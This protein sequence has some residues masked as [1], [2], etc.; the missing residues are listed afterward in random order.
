MKK[1]ENILFCTD[2]DGTLLNDD[3]QIS[4]ENLD[5]IEYFKNE[6][7]SFSFIT[8]RPYLISKDICEKIKPNVPL[9]CFNGGGLYDVSKDEFIW[10]VV[11]DKSA[12]EIVDFVNKNFDKMGIQINTQK[13]IY[14]MKESNGTR[15]FREITNTPY[16]YGDYNTIND[17]II[18]VIFATDDGEYMDEFSREIVKHPLASRFAFVRSEF[19]L[20]ELLPK[21]VNKG[22]VLK[23]LADY[24]KIDMKRTI[25]IGDYDNDVSMLKMAGLGVAV[26][27]AVPAAKEA[28]DYIT[29]SNN[30]HAI[31]KIID[32]IDKGIIKLG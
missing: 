32:D 2:L 13:S 21:E 4:K 17:P 12:F 31:A 26:D 25:A 23:V 19:I 29:V 8:G 5:A 10:S 1:F 28:A 9:G 6:G 11:L 14:Y 15:L 18:K 24:L 3:R 16:I 20:F 7:G 27:N 30:E 22:N